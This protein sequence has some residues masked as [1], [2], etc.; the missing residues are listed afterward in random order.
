MAQEDKRFVEPADPAKLSE[1]ERLAWLVYKLRDVAE[2]DNMVP[3]KVQVLF[4]PHDAG[5]AAVQLRKMGKA[6][7]PTLIG[8]LDDRRPTRSVGNA[9]NGGRVLRYCDVALEIL[10]AMSGEVFDGRTWRGAYLSTASPA[11]R[12]QIVGRVREW[13][14]ANQ[15]KTEVEWIHRSLEKD[16]LGGMWDR[17]ALAERLVELE[18]PGCV[19]LLRQCRVKEPD[20]PL[21]VGL[22]WEAGGKE[23]L[24]DLKAAAR[25]SN[26]DIRAQGYRYLIEG[27]QEEYIAKAAEDL[28]RAVLHPSKD[29]KG[30]GGEKEYVPLMSALAYSANLQA[31]LVVAEYM[32]SADAEV[33]WDAERHVLYAQRYWEPKNPGLARQLLPH[34]MAFLEL[35]GQDPRY[36][37]G[38][39]SVVVRTAKLPLAWPEDT[40]TPEVQ[41][42]KVRQLQA[43]VKEHPLDTRARPQQSPPSPRAPRS[44]RRQ[45]LRRGRR[46]AGRF[47]MGLSRSR[48]RRRWHRLRTFC[49][50]CCWFRS[51]T[52]RPRSSSGIF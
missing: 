38:A 13:W 1:K 42:E 32:G 17:F 34:L 49:R 28:A 27:G 3:G 51:R 16:G 21:L 19:Q 50:R 41:A 23:V 11:E 5:S 37:F 35:P 18:G 47:R 15:D 12:T 29:Y 44:L 48:R 30:V 7:V 24:D 36:R 46:I 14:T 9:L 2:Q 26:A 10:E 6:A 4:Y 20:N 52:Q 45:R 25:S 40:P 22:L 43:W 8:L 39:A 33:A 31:V